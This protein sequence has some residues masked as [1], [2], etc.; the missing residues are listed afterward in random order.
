[1]HLNYGMDNYFVRYLQK[2]LSQNYSNTIQMTG[3]FDK[4]THMGLINYL[5]LPNTE[6][7]FEVTRIFRETYPELNSLFIPHQMNDEVVFTSKRIDKETQDF[8]TNNIQNFRDTARSLGWEV[9]EIQNYIDWFMD[10]NDDGSINDADRA[11]LNNIVYNEAV[12][13]DKTMERADLN[14]DSIIDKEDLRL[15]SSYILSGKLSLRLKS[16]G[17]KNFFPNQDMKIFINLFDNTWMYDK[18]LRSDDGTD[19]LLHD[20]ITKEWKVAVIPVTPGQQITITHASPKAT[21]LVVGSSPAQLRTNF[22]QFFCQNVQD[23]KLYPGEVLEYQVP[24][25]GDGVGIYDGHFVLIQV[26]SN[27]GNLSQDL[28]HTVV[29]K[30]GDINFDG[31]IDNIDLKLL[32]DYATYK[33]WEP[34][35]KQLAVMDINKDGVINQDDVQLMLNY[36]AGI[37]EDLGET[38]WTYVAPEDVNEGDNL[39]KLLVID[40]W[41]KKEILGTTVISKNIIVDGNV[42]V[43]FSVMEG[44]SEINIDYT[45]LNAS[46]I[47]RDINGVE[48]FNNGSVNSKETITS[49]VA[50]GWYSVE[51][52]A[53]GYLRTKVTGIELKRG[54]QTLCKVKLYPG[55]VNDV[56]S[57]LDI[58]DATDDSELTSNYASSVSDSKYNIRYDLNRDGSVNSDDRTL[59]LANN[60]KL[61]ENPDSG[62]LYVNINTFEKL[63]LQNVTEEKSIIRSTWG[64]NYKDFVQS[65]WIVHDKFL[66]YL[67]G[68]S[69]HKYSDSE[70]ITYMQTLL[71]EL[72]PQYAND[73]SIFQTGYY[74]PGMRALVR[75]YQMS[76]ITY[77][78]GDLNADKEIDEVDALLL[79]NYL[80][81]NG[82]LSDRQLVLADVNQDG[83]VDEEDYNI[84][85]EQIAGTTDFLSIYQIPFYI[86]YIDVQTEAMLENDIN[87][88]MYIK[89]VST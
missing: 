36:L 82:T 18:A 4:Q 48:V 35:E 44:T 64:I 73:R 12:Y 63:P 89:E 50:E 65:P 23:V 71:K 28:E 67:C 25:D 49:N 10:I 31:R 79:R 47:L 86:G 51:C 38:K 41:D 68:M 52:T 20:D 60:S 22:T 17:R 15:L 43:E 7:Q 70:D 33:N 39:S 32:A 24:K 75:Q 81:N 37:S 74:S 30:S 66:N 54:Y 2:F 26:P 87:Q 3:K 13:D 61:S 19:D 34:T 88:E 5:N 78:L 42:K 57:S 76:K 55:N 56:G 29:L 85:M 72:F 59:L 84:I 53:P 8:L 14:R 58:I 46:V 62:T 11:I 21:R 6:T 27:L 80:D 40:G 9:E 83:V 1:M 69:V 45:K 16:S 77:Y